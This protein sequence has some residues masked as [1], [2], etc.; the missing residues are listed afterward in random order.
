MFYFQKTKKEL[1]SIFFCIAFSQAAQ[2]Q[3]HSKQ[4]PRPSVRPYLWLYRGRIGCRPRR[5]RIQVCACWLEDT[6]AA[7]RTGGV[8]CALSFVSMELPIAWFDYW[9]SL[10]QL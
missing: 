8:V 1:A 9:S 3:I 5:D 10:S 2:A 4:P 7:E 6:R